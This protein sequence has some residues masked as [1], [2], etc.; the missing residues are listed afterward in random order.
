MSKR[1]HSRMVNNIKHYDRKRKR[2]TIEVSKKLKN[3]HHLVVAT[4]LSNCNGNG[5]RSQY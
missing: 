2:I 5:L 3:H 1:Y 4:V